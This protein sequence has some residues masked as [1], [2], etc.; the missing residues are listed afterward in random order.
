[1]DGV[2][3]YGMHRP[4]ESVYTNSPEEAL[5]LLQQMGDELRQEAAAIGKLMH[6]IRETG[7]FPGRAWQ[8]DSI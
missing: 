2:S 4:E 1:M 5:E 6:Y 8:Q 7:R 3:F